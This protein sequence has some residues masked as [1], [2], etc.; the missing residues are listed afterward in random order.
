MSYAQFFAIIAIFIGAFIILD[1]LLSIWW[2]NGELPWQSQKT[3]DRPGVSE[4]ERYLSELRDLTSAK[5]A[6]G[7]RPSRTL[8]GDITLLWAH[9]KQI[10]RTKS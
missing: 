5:S 6:N 8:R 10:T 9:F 7:H 2:K 1:G 3:H 4:H